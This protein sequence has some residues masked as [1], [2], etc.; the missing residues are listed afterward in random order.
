MI[1]KE[2]DFPA[3]CGVYIFKDMDGAPLYIGKAKDIRKRLKS[4]FKE[5]SFKKIKLLDQTE[6]IDFIITLDELSALFLEN[7]LIKKHQPKYNVNLKD[8]KTY[9]FIE[10]TIQDKYPKIFYTRKIRE[11]SLYFG[12]FYPAQKAKKIISFVQ[13]NFG[14][15]ICKRDL[16]KHYKK[17]CLYFYLKKCLG[18]C[19]PGL[20]GKEKYRRKVFQAILFIKGKN[21][22][23]LNEIKKEIE[24]NSKKLRF[25]EAKNL[26][27]I[28]NSIEEIKERT[29]IFKS[30]I[31]NTD[32]FGIYGEGKKLCLAVL[33]F[34]NDNIFGK[35][36]YLFEEIE[37]DDPSFFLSQ[38][39]P[40][41]YISNP[42]IPD[43]IILPF[44]S[45]EEIFIDFLKKGRGKK[46]I[47][48][49]PEKGK[50]KKFLQIAEENAKEYF[51]HRIPLS[52]VEDLKK[53]LN[54][55][56]LYSISGVDI[57][58]FQGRNRYG[59]IVFF[60][61]GKFEKKKYRTFKLKTD[62]PRDDPGGIY[63]IIK[64]YLKR[65][66]NEEKRIP[67]LILID[68]GKV[69]L[70]SALKAKNETGAITTLISIEKGEEK[71][72]LE[73]INEPLILEK[74]SPALLLLMKIRDE[75]HRFV[76]GIH[77]RISSKKFI[78]KNLIKN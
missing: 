47:I 60:E 51:H 8:D 44:S 10:I 75:A 63:E 49:V 26:K 38:I 54:L 15:A 52:G 57:S 19:V 22:K 64:R 61:N 36:T 16:N 59:G 30:K 20:T 48:K 33:N 42:L 77:R 56:K 23:L 28:Y 72:Y 17:P 21:K 34:K 50:D 65:L 39:L 2:Y 41:Y 4:H 31:K 43:K 55:K 29:S 14:I 67:D 32:V 37:T 46:V 68:G 24:F 58:H 25:E 1:F 70:S 18:P 74:N 40:Q 45:K 71:I 78:K 13:K 9:P 53:I 35:K 62:D 3:R 69:Q 7:N 27:E 66:V 76:I 5:E 12:P 11:G 6:K 73:E